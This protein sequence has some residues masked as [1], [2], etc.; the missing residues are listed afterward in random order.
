MV[1]PFG[2]GQIKSS[3]MKDWENLKFFWENLSRDYKK[4]RRGE[5][6]MTPGKARGRKHEV[7]EESAAAD[8]TF[9]FVF[10]PLNPAGQVPSS[11][12]SK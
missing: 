2:F 12:P 11:L 10:S 3:T 9:F 4:P 8:D 6:I 1:Q 5:I 7:G